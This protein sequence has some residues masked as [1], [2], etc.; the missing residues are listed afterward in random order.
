[1]YHELSKTANKLKLN[2]DETELI[3]FYS[4]Y[5]PQKSF[6][7]LHFG[8][9]L[10]HPSQHFRDIS[11][12]FDCTLSMIP[13]VN[14]VCKSAFYQRRNIVCI[15]KYLSPKYTEFLAHAFVSSKLDFC[16]SLLYS[17]LKHLLQKLHSVQ[18]AAARSVTSPSKFDHVTPLLMQL[19]WLPITER[20]KNKIFLFTFEAS[21][22]Y[23]L[24]SP[25]NS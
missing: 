25:K 3:Y 1:M 16:N 11:T 5:S 22:T 20:I 14:S 4:K 6:I 19:H 23:R 10:I 18:N 7:P 15:R 13:Q 8:T 21:T 12:I 2:K 24:P 9:D 17:I